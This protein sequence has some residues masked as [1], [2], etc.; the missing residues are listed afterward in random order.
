[1]ISCSPE[2]LLAL[3]SCLIAVVASADAACPQSMHLT[4]PW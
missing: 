4:T 3:Q 2:A 1:M